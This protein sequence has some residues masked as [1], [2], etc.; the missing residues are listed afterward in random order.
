[1]LTSYNYP[2]NIREL[3]NIVEYCTNL[4]QDDKIRTEHLPK[5]LFDPSK[6]PDIAQDQTTRILPPSALPQQTESPQKDWLAIEK[7]MIV[8]A[9][10][11]VHGNRSKAAKELG[12]GRT[13]L[14]RKLS[15][16]N[17]S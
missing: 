14:W 16:H 4:C 7:D 12:W 8:Q 10:M 17:L 13:T 3:R 2:G 6:V 11:K 15:L 1:M 9:L 5:Y